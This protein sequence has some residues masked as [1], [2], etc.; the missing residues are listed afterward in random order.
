M[1]RD[2]IERWRVSGTL[3]ARTA[4]H[5]GG[6]AGDPDTD[7]PLARDGANRWCIPGTS[8]AGAFRAWWE[9]AFGAKDTA[10]LWGTV[11]KKSGSPNDGWASFIIV[12]DA[13]LTVP[14]GAVELRDGVGIDRI[15]GTAADRI[16]HDRAVLPAGTTLAL[17]ITVEVERERSC[18]EIEA[19]LAHFLTALAEGRIPLGAG[20]TRGLGRVALKKDG[21]LIRR[22]AL[23]DRKGILETLRTNGSVVSLDEMDRSGAAPAAPRRLRVALTWEPLGPVMSRAALDG[24]VVDALPL[25]GREGNTIRPLLTGAGVKGV[26]RAQ[27]ERIV[28]TLLDLSADGHFL[29]QVRVPLVRALFGDPGEAEDKRLGRGA[30]SVED[31]YAEW[32]TD[33]DGHRTMIAEGKAPGWR[34]AHHV[35]ID[36]WTGGAAEG[37]LF[38]VLEPQG[39]TWRPLVLELDLTRLDPE[40]TLAA[41]SL[42][43]LVLDDLAAGRL[44]LGFAGNRGMGAIAV[45]GIDLEDDGTAVPSG[46]DVTAR[47]VLGG[48][49]GRA[50]DGGLLAHIAEDQRD[51][52]AKAWRSW[53]DG[54]A[55]KQ[56]GAV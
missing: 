41:L 16:K 40:E 32:K 43:L 17:S 36:R 47:T 45:R 21:L 51:R 15:H 23:T 22:Q 11:P 4:I 33:A 55:A 37:L 13:P 10:S 7:L 31:C 12:E 9:A 24:L 6:M 54:A 50:L 39:V 1:P 8:L 20:R 29:D 18:A 2:L 35:A 38:S 49:K 42:L 30:L 56:R 19:M 25:M 52:L 44:P 27:A 53:I 5:V 46:D 14:G 48:L 3:V 28:R 34:A 26:L